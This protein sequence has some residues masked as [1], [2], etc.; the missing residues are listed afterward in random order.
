MRNGGELEEGTVPS[1]TVNP[2]H[3]NQGKRKEVTVHYPKMIGDN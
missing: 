1:S 3:Q 2:I